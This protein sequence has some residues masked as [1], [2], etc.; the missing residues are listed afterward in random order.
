MKLRGEVELE[1][2]NTT[3]L[4]TLHSAIWASCFLI[5]L[6]TTCLEKELIIH[7]GPACIT[8]QGSCFR[9]P[10]KKRDKQNKPKFTQSLLQQGLA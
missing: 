2:L 7:P 4:D 1:Y 6:G 8:K 10:Q 5:G 9:W 3:F